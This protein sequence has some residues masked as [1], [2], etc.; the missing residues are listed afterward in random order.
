[1]ATTFRLTA[2]CTLLMAAAAFGEAQP[3]ETPP[4]TEAELARELEE[5]AEAMAFQ[6]QLLQAAERRA[7]DAERRAADAERRA[8]DAERRAI[9]GENRAME[10]ERR[11]I[12]AESRAV[13]AERL[14]IETITQSTGPSDETF[15]DAIGRATRYRRPNRTSENDLDDGSHYEQS[16]DDRS[17]REQC[18]RTPDQEIIGFRYESRSNTEAL[19]WRWKQTTGGAWRA[20]FDGTDLGQPGDGQ[21]QRV[22]DT[23]STWYEYRPMRTD[24]EGD[25]V[26][27]ITCESVGVEEI[28]VHYHH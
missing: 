28:D 2:I 5:I 10:A 6:A 17:Y 15:A 20:Y 14:A 21:I 1:M 18:R 19:H 26:I 27:L 24:E 16:S 4:R 3:P 7:A 8:I 22:A 11:A 23:E 9:D 12:E 25:F 13:E